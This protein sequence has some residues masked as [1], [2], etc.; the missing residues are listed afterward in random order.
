M[1][2]LAITADPSFLIS[3]TVYEDFSHEKAI[4]S[5]SPAMNTDQPWTICC[6][7]WKN[8]LKYQKRFAAF[9]VKMQ[10]QRKLRYFFRH[11]TQS[12]MTSNRHIVEPWITYL[13]KLWQNNDI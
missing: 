4:G 1:T 11:L 3:V 10:A 8:S 7:N 5:A 13:T 2:K 6:Y 12:R 9:Y